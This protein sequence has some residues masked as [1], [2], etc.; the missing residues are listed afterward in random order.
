MYNWIIANLV[1]QVFDIIT[2]NFDCGI[3][4]NFNIS[5][6]YGRCGCCQ[7]IFG[8]F[9]GR[10]MKNEVMEAFFA[11]HPELEDMQFTV[12]FMAELRLLPWYF[13]LFVLVLVICVMIGYGIVSLFKKCFGSSN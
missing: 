11:K 6:M 2:D 5:N 8:L 4:F 13:L 12:R 3:P 7:V 1:I 10:K 9:F